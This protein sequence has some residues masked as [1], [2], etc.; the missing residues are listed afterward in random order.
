[1]QDTNFA[2]ACNKIIRELE[3]QSIATHSI[4]H[5]EAWL[6]VYNFAKLSLFMVQISQAGWYCF[7]IYP[8]LSL[9][10]Q[11]EKQLTLF[12]SWETLVM[13]SSKPWISEHKLQL[14]LMM[15]SLSVTAFPTQYKTKQI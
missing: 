12:W 1:M 15:A 5:S 4:S 13:F 10:G 14:A 6:S 9:L 7:R 3:A 11:G 2:E 8:S